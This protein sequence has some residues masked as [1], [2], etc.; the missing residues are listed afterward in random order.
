MPCHDIS[1]E[2]FLQKSA[3]SWHVQMVPLVQVQVLK[4]Q[5]PVQV[6]VLRHQVPVPVPV[7]ESQVQVLV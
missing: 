7:P 6:P 1:L 4:S 3:R 5:V 2:D